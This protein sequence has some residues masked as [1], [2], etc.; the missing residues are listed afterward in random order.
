MALPGPILIFS[1]GQSYVLD[2]E[3]QPDPASGRARGEWDRLQYQ[4]YMF[5]RWKTTQV[6]SRG[7][8]KADLFVFNIKIK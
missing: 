7:L 3:K 2:M 5:M 8:P 4:K 1:I 6:P